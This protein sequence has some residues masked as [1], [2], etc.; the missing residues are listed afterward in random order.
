MVKASFKCTPFNYSHISRNSNAQL[1]SIPLDKPPHFD[2]EDYS[3][4]SHKM[5][6]HLCSLHP[7]IW[8]IVEIGMGIPEVNDENY[9]LW[10]QKKSY[11]ATLKPP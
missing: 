11:T 5:K 3:R 4:W 8:D 7:S 10:M 1:L 2:G 6:S 9:N